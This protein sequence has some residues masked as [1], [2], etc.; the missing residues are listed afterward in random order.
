MSVQVA[1]PARRAGSAELQQSGSRDRR[2]I[3]EM[4]L[5]LGHF[6]LG[7]GG[8]VRVRHAVDLGIGGR[9]EGRGG[10]QHRG[11]GDIGHRSQ[12]AQLTLEQGVV[13][14]PFG[15]RVAEAAFP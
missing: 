1:L 7:L 12:F 10:V 6:Q 3:V 5:D 2:D 4:N 13:G 15:K 11:A 9:A 14:G 8:Q